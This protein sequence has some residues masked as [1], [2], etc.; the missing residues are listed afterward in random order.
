MRVG[1]LRAQ[2]R[3]GPTAAS[4]P[5]PWF[6]PPGPEVA[7]ASGF[8]THVGTS[9]QEG[10]LR[11]VSLSPGETS[12]Q[13][14]PSPGSRPHPEQTVRS[15]QGPCPHCPHAGPPS[16]AASPCLSLLGVSYGRLVP[17]GHAD[18]GC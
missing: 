5:G 14:L 10:V 13:P 4:L 15:E 7:S 3:E 8:G 6:A 18:P 12:Q 2:P 17:P 11:A 16:P 9:D 1:V